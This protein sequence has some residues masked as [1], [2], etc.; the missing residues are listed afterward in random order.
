MLQSECRVETCMHYAACC[1]C[2]RCRPSCY[3]MYCCRRCRRCLAREPSSGRDQAA[4]M[5][6]HAP[7]RIYSS[8]STD[9]LTT[10]TMHYI[11]DVSVHTYA[12]V[13]HRPATPAFPAED[14]CS[15]RDSNIPCIKSSRS[16]AESSDGKTHWM[17]RSCKLPLARWQRNTSLAISHVHGSLHGGEF[18]RCRPA[19]VCKDLLEAFQSFST[20]SLESKMVVTW[21][22]VIAH[23]LSITCP[24]P[25]ASRVSGRNV[26]C[27]V[28]S[29]VGLE[30]G[31][32]PPARRQYLNTCT[33]ELS[34]RDPAT[35][36]ETP[37]TWQHPFRS[38]HLVLMV[39][40][41]SVQRA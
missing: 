14:A 23:A 11:H 22:S 3:C 6:C 1:C 15:R 19:C 2:C 20:I 25:G 37:R 38:C 24:M 9:R 18:D 40:E 16:C 17:P 28:M 13:S 26:G 31:S 7:S 21:I 35:S 36:F 27:D 41:F 5:P 34:E 12:P 33:S 8:R 10:C 29:V 4:D 30:L 39:P 32:C